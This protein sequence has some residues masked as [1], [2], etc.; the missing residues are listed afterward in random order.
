MTDNQAPF[1]H[2]VNTGSDGLDAKA[3][4]VLLRATG[5]VMPYAGTLKK[6]KGWSTHSTTSGTVN[7]ALFKFTPNPSSA[8]TVSLVLLDEVGHTPA[9]NNTVIDIE[10]TSFTDADVAE[11]D[12][13]ISGIKG[14]ATQ[15]TYFVTTL[16][17]EWD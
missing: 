10:E 17:V 9:G 11:G 4:N 12:I 1:E 3:V 8:S 2:A 6:W 14:S 15:V 16:E 13:I 7:I 5:V